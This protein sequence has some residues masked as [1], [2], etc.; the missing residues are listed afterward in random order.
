MRG[1]ADYSEGWPGTLELGSGFGV[2]VMRI[3]AEIAMSENFLL[4]G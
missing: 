1:L 4:S 2:L 3:T